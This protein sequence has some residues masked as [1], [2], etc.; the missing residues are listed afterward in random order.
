VNAL[1]R[2][3]QQANCPTLSMYGHY[4]RVSTDDLSKLLAVVDAAGGVVELS[5][6][7][8]ERFPKERIPQG[9]ADEFYSYQANGSASI[10][11]TTIHA[12]ADA[13]AALTEDTT[14]CAT[15]AEPLSTDVLL[16]ER[17]AFIV[18]KGLW[19]DFVDSTRTK[20]KPLLQTDTAHHASNSRQGYGGIGVGAVAEAH[21]GSL[22]S[23]VP[24][25]N[26][27]IA[28]GLLSKGEG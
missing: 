16:R 27:L 6:L 2:V 15:V 1:E 13:L 12:I 4:V 22:P 24:F 20:T 26:D 21:C 8:T 25:A 23:V 17:D 3:K 9:V 19:S 14:P 5:R 7:I 18:S 28:S 11:F 10:S